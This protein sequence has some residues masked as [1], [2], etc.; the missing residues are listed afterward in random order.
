M[1]FYNDYDKN[2]EFLLNKREMIS[3]THKMN[4]EK[5]EKFINLQLN[6]RR[7]RAAR[8]LI[9][10]THYITFN[11]LFEHIR[12]VINS[13]YDKIDTT[14]K[15][16]MYVGE[17]M[18]SSYFISTIA[19][20]FIKL[21]G[22][23]LPEPVDRFTGK[24]LNEIDDNVLLVLDDFSYSGSQLSGLLSNLFYKRYLLLEKKLPNVIVGL[25]GTSSHAK[26]ILSR[27]TFEYDQVLV[28]EL[29]EKYGEFDL[30]FDSPFEICSDVTYEALY[31]ALSTEEFLDVLFYFSPT[32]Y[33]SPIISLYSDHKIADPIST[34][35][36]TLQY[37]Q[38][39][40]V[41][42]E[43]FTPIRENL[44][45]ENLYTIGKYYNNFDR[46]STRY[47]IFMDD[48]KEYVDSYF[49]KLKKYEKLT[50]SDGRLIESD[51]K[52]TTSNEKLIGNDGKLTASG[53]MSFN[54]L[55]EKCHNDMGIF[56]LMEFE[57]IPYYYFIMTDYLLNDELNRPDSKDEASKYEDAIR[58]I[59]EPNGRCPISFYRY[60]MHK[61]DDSNMEIID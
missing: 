55:I 10:N 56:E 54:I 46:W 44:I 14:K 9:E 39:L 19:V 49:K 36:T 1:D 23:I 52:L 50:T 53:N 26:K 33:G 48:F 24:I 42:L 5:I 15:I 28:D 12:N 41:D 29:L 2:I 32:N 21:R 61:H 58:I 27:V 31:D 22:D 20:Y 60:E 59:N 47:D 16:Y 40:P 18:K 43:Y 11:Q 13:I 37:G 8:N 7:K 3:G 4:P 57:K 35:S 6:D 17:K 34:F 51:E 25:V 45:L 30:S 38:I